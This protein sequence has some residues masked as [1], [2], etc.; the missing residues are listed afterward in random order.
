MASTPDTS[1]LADVRVSDSESADDVQSEH[2]DAPRD[3]S[4]SVGRKRARR[5]ETWKQ[6]IRK[7]H[8][9]E[10]KAYYSGMA[11][12]HIDARK[13]GPPCRD[14]CFDKVTMPVVEALFKEFW[15]MGNYDAQ[16]AYLQ[17]LMI[18]M[19][20]KRRRKSLDETKRTV[21]IMYNVMYGDSE[22]HVCKQGFL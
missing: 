18:P 22:Y 3:A 12:K 17:K 21:T 15:A 14:G 4:V 19:P 2:S 8:R 5:P 11:K 20:V 6:S 1:G 7:K 10:G 13:I 16:T 9:N